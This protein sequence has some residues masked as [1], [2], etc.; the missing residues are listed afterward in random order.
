MEWGKSLN[1]SILRIGEVHI[2]T[3]KEVAF[4]FLKRFYCPLGMTQDQN[5]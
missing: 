1:Y 5:G 2:N 4:D 3:L